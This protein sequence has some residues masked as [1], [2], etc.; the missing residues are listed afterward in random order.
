MDL[1]INPGNFNSCVIQLIKITLVVKTSY[2]LANNGEILVT[3]H[4]LQS[5]SPKI[6]KEILTWTRMFQ[7]LSLLHA[8]F[9][10][11][12]AFK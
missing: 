5:G 2:T 3:A 10:L 7:S 6:K 11:S 8:S 1:Y 9:I 4:K 12:L